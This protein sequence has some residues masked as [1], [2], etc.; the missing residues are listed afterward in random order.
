MD[1]LVAAADTYE[2][3]EDEHR[4]RDRACQRHEER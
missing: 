2:K 3:S 1:A 4:V